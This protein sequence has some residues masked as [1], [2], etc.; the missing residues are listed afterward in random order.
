MIDFFKGKVFKGEFS[1][2]RKHYR[3]GV[4]N[5][6]KYCNKIQ[7]MQFSVLGFV[8]RDGINE[9]SSLGHI[10]LSLVNLLTAIILNTKMFF[11]RKAAKMKQYHKHQV[12]YVL[13]D[14]CFIKYF[15]KGNSDTV[16]KHFWRT[17][18]LYDPLHSG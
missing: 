8:G 14:I 9:K 7:E 2:N 5:L 15:I 13:R 1:K 18:R 4:Y 3:S 11:A 6:S 10:L 17:L 12:K 16:R